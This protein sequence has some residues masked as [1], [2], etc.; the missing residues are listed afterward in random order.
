MKDNGLSTA[1]ANSS[2]VVSNG[3]SE[4]MSSAA[5]AIY[6]LEHLLIL[7]NLPIAVIP[8]EAFQTLA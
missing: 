2:K 5:V 8:D 4:S 7:E 1:S 6:R 3:R